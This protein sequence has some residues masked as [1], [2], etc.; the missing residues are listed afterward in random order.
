MTIS[1]IMYPT[2]GS[3]LHCTVLHYTALNYNDIVWIREG[4]PS[5]GPVHDTMVRTRTQYH[6]AV[7]RCRRQSDETRARRL[8]EASLKFKETQTY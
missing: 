8:F 1:P 3:S 6:Y 7:R 4:R 5:T 2:V